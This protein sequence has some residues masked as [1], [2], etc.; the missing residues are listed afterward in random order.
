MCLVSGICIL[1]NLFAYD[2][3][4]HRQKDMIYSFKQLYIT[5]YAILTSFKR[6][7]NKQRILFY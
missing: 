3:M 2:I 1:H 4:W 5:F 6:S 7:V